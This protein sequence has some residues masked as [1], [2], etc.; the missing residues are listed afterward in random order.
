[1]H[2]KGGKTKSDYIIHGSYMKDSNGDNDADNLKILITE[3]LAH[4]NFVLKCN[5]IVFNL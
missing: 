3:A 1:M 4:A 2:T 5:S